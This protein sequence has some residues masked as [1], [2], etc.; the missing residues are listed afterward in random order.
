MISIRTITQLDQA[1]T[2][3]IPFI[4]DDKLEENLLK[5]A[6]LIGYEM[7]ELGN[8][9]TA[10]KKETLIVATP[11]KKYSKVIFL[12]W[13]KTLLVKKLLMLLGL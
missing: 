11:S 13:G 8:S 7:E 10:E 4:K 5:R 3:I 12:V 9:F 2:L 1:N 6:K